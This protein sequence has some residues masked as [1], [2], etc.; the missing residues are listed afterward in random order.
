MDQNEEEQLNSECT[1][2]Q[3]LP[4]EVPRKIVACRGHKDS[5]KV[6]IKLSKDMQFCDSKYGVR[7]NMRCLHNVEAPH[8]QG[9][10]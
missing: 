2:E 3:C 10:M 8:F 6:P 5:S 7:S 1:L 9:V 4:E